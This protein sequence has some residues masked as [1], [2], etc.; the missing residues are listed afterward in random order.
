M[1]TITALYSS[2]FLQNFNVL[3]LPAYWKTSH[4]FD[5]P[6]TLTAD[7]DCEAEIY[8]TGGGLQP[9]FAT[10]RKSLTLPHLSNNTTSTSGVANATT[11]MLTI[12]Q[13]VLVDKMASKDGFYCR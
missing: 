4:A 9:R 5:A 13:K 11:G 6:K 10:V 8:G 12:Q 7:K 3:H 2:E 1:G